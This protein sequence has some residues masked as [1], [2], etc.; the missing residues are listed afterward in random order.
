MTKFWSAVGCSKAKAIQ[1]HGIQW[2]TPMRFANWTLGERIWGTPE[3]RLY[4]IVCRSQAIHQNAGPN[5][6][7]N[8]VRNPHRL[9]WFLLYNKYRCIRPQLRRGL[10]YE[11]KRIERENVY[12]RSW[13]ASHPASHCWASSDSVRLFP[14]LSQFYDRKLKTAGSLRLLLENSKAQKK[15]L[16]IVNV[17]LQRPPKHASLHTIG[18]RVK[19]MRTRNLDPADTRPSVVLE[20]GDT[21]TPARSAAIHEQSVHCS[22][23]KAVSVG[24]EREWQLSVHLL[25][26]AAAKE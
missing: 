20:A 14:K 26:F 7:L 16:R 18:F 8:R 22:E 13:R 6:I 24:N 11:R 21:I 15:W 3:E 5:S 9:C 17:H 19:N 25:S 12:K 23:A 1:H 10:R 4:Y 2:G